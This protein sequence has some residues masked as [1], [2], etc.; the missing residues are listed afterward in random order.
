MDGM[1]FNPNLKLG[2]QFSDK[3][4]AGVE[5]YGTTGSLTRLAP[6]A[7]Q[8]HMIYPS[9]D[10]FLSPDWEFNAG[11]GV[12]VSGSGD[13]NIVKVILGRRFPW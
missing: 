12:L 3:V 8:S 9:I 5:Y 7:E 1:I 6:S 11:F 10:L 13:R 2:W 4:Q